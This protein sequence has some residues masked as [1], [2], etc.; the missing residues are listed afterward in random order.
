MLPEIKNLLV[1]QERDQRLSRIETDL[2]F[3]PREE[4]NIED[5]LLKET[6][7]LEELKKQSMLMESQR[8]DLENQVATQR[9]Q[10]NRYKKQQL[11]TRKNEEYQ[12][13][14]H[15]IE[16]AE[17]DIVSLDDQQLEMMEK[18]EVLAAELARESAT[19]KIH[20]ASAAENRKSLKDKFQS[21]T[22]EKTSLCADIADKEKNIDPDLLVRYRRIF[23]NKG[24]AAIVTIVHGNTC[25]GCHMK[26]TQQTILSAKS[27]NSIVQCENCGRILY[28]VG[29]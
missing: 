6:S 2:K 16:R 29:D 23:K 28:W 24:D 18:N 21:L 27:E 14:G 4:K 13:L 25:S 15:E 7:H 20:Q 22:V 3:I 11:D 8:K 12:A 26:L 5:K 17:K 1:L 9:E 19:V 10:I